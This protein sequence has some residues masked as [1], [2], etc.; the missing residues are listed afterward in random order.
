MTV[1]W[2]LDLSK[3]TFGNRLIYV[4]ADWR[5]DALPNVHGRWCGFSFFLIKDQ[6]A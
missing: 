5:K 2:V 1:A 4:G 6:V 3:M